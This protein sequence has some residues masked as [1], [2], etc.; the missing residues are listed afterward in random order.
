VRDVRLALRAGEVTALMGRNGSG[1]SSLLWALQGSGPRQGGS[2]KVTGA[3]GGPAADPKRLPAARARQLVGLVPQTPT[4]LL[5]LETVAQ[6]LAQSDLEAD[7]AGGPTARQI[8]DR[9]APGIP[10]DT[11][12]RDLSEGQK[13]ALV[14]A[15]Q[16][17]AAPRVV[18]LDEPTRGL[19][20]HAKEAL[21]GIV[22]ALAAEGRTVVVSTHDVEF[23]ASAADR[24]VVM[25][26]GEIVA[27]GP[28]AEVIVASP[29]FAPQTAKILAPLAYLTARQVG[30]ALE[31]AEATR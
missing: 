25:A 4:D 18:L 9:L 10:D 7:G 27:D 11:H 23:V 3:G 30:A 29:T 6:E 26:E 13:L 17:S 14:L 28:T 15:I 22:D 16:L 2:V 8:L 5:Y 21:T 31:T 24:V 19:D 12:P 20:Y 1:K